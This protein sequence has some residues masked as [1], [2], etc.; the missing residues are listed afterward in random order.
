[1]NWTALC[2]WGIKEIVN[3]GNISLI[4]LVKENKPNAWKIVTVRFVNANQV[5]CLQFSEVSVGIT[6]TYY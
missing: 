3:T 5:V 1:M 4:F 2:Y 6:E